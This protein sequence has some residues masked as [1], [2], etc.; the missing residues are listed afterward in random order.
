MNLQD[1][2]NLISQ[3]DTAGAIQALSN[4]IQE[5]AGHNLRLRNDLIVVS[6]RYAALQH[7]ERIGE[8]AMNDATLENTLV[9]RALLNLIDEIETGKGQPLQETQLGNTPPGKGGK[10][11]RL[12]LAIIGV[13]AIAAVIGLIFFLRN[14]TGARDNNSYTNTG[15]APFHNLRPGAI[16]IC[17]HNP[18]PTNN[19]RAESHGQWRALPPSF[20][21]TFHIASPR[22]GSESY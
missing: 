20:R 2:R 9:N 8:M 11:S 12:M 22:P 18:C 17:H 15:P 4:I 13:L 5:G 1:I 21:S 19:R 6:N 7:K 3:G 14:D 16:F 10:N